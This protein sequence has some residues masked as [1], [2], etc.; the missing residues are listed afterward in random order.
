M[1]LRT[2]GGVRS[3]SRLHYDNSGILYLTKIVWL[4]AGTTTSLLLF[5]NSRGLSTTMCDN[6]AETAVFWDIENARIPS[7]YSAREMYEKLCTVL[8]G[9]GRWR[10]G[11]RIIG[12]LQCQRRLYSELM[13]MGCWLFDI[14]PNGKPNRAD[15]VIVV[16][17]MSFALDHP[18]P[19]TII[20]ITGD[21]DYGYSLSKL[22]AR[23]YRIVL[24]A[25][26]TAKASL[27]LS[28]DVILEWERDVLHMPKEAVLDAL[29]STPEPRQLQPVAFNQ[30]LSQSAPM[31]RGGMEEEVKAAVGHQMKENDIVISKHETAAVGNSPL[32]LSPPSIPIEVEEHKQISS[33]NEDSSVTP[34]LSPHPLVGRAGPPLD[35]T[36]DVV[37]FDD[38]IRVLDA[39]RRDGRV[40]RSLVGSALTHLRTSH[41]SFKRHTE[42]AERRGIVEMGGCGGN[43]WIRLTAA[44]RATRTYH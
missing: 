21:S 32:T 13:G 38:L 6:Q 18:P 28:A 29:I 40:L 35:L 8:H 31:R 2:N 16:E 17:M 34:A 20:L 43:D 7:R 9:Y 22:R 30:H 5:R 10:D 11:I 41:Q 14:P 39:V 24:V 1:S 37:E 33:W 3:W 23:G 15:G 42:E 4:S 44:F 27:T 36:G 26:S 19:T 12:D 25:L